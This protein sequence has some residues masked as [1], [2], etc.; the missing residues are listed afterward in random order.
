MALSFLHP[1]DAADGSAGIR[2]TDVTGAFASPS[3]KP[4]LPSE[5]FHGER[6]PFT[7]MLCLAAKRAPPCTVLQARREPHPSRSAGHHVTIEHARSTSVLNDEQVTPG[8]RTHHG[9]Q[10]IFARLGAAAS[11]SL[12]L[13]ALSGTHPVS[14][15]IPY[16]QPNA[17]E[18]IFQALFPATHRSLWGDAR[19]TQR[20]RNARKIADRGPDGTASAALEQVC[21]GSLLPGSDL[22][23]KASAGAQ[24]PR[25]IFGDCAVSRQAV[26]AAVERAPRLEPPHLGS[27]R[28]DL[29]ADDVRGI[30]GDEI[31]A[32]DER[33]AE[34]AGDE[35]RARANACVSGVAARDLKRRRA[36][37]GADPERQRQFVQQCDENGPRPGAEIGDMA[38]R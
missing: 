29:A 38:W 33:L 1:H 25:C 9:Y 21:H 8:L 2:A 7:E 14:G 20:A 36:D 16:T 5:P 31:E 15:P 19:Q 4:Q 22:D 30:A 3:Q 13:R 28:I 35:G 34:I 18:A 6:Q 32:A 12:K 27:E 23:D 17:S 24:K 37:V 10:M 11:P 26:V